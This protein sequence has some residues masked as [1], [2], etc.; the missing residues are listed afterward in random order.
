MIDNIKQVIVTNDAPTAAGP[1]SQAIKANS[2]VYL[3][4]Q[5]PLDPKSGQLVTG[6][7]EAQVRQ[8]INNL[9]AV[10]EAAGGGLNDMVRVCVYLIDLANFPIVNALMEEYFDKPYPA[11]TTIQVSALPKDAAVEM[12]A[13]MVLAE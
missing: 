9:A 1:Y 2:T 5:I 8:V 7:I 11:R 12:D 4:G 10:A 6:G 3:A 13:I